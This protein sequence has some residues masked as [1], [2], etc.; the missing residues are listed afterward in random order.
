MRRDQRGTITIWVLGLTVYSFVS[1]V[2]HASFDET[3]LE[4]GAN[5]LMTPFSLVFLVWS[6]Y[7]LTAKRIP[8]RELI[9][10][11]LIGAAGLAVY[12][13]GAAVYVPHLFSSYATRYGVIGAVFAMISS[14]FCMMVVVVASA[15]V[16]REVS[17][18]LRRI[19]EGERPP[20]D[21]IRQEWDAIIAEARSRWDALRE[22]VE[23]RRRGEPEPVQQVAGRDPRVDAGE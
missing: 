10:F 17:E 16:G 6:G 18:E 14:L 4:L 12:S 7:V 8:W 2:I 11:G 3:R 23:R 20:D 13:T 9:P 15:S 1:G 19:R 5:L 21:E 22:Q